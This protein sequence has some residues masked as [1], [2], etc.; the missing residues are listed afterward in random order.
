MRR[1]HYN[2]RHNLHILLYF[3]PVLFDNNKRL[4]TL[5]VIIISGDY[6]ITKI[7]DYFINIIIF[8]L[9]HYNNDDY[10][11]LLTI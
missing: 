7:F 5:T 4:I 1:I 6:C 2:N 10:R 9:I 3:R 8:Y 11:N